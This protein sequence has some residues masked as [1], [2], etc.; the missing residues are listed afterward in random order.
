M[1]YERI[2]AMHEAGD[3]SRCRFGCCPDN[4][5]PPQETEFSE[6]YREASRELA[7][8]LGRSD[9]RVAVALDTRGYLGT[10]PDLPGIV[11]AELEGNALMI[12]DLSGEE[13]GMF[14]MLKVRRARRLLEDCL[15]GVYS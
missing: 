2:K 13:P 4:P 15:I 12:E 7:E 8:R 5:E 11:R 1:A 6:S 14:E 3:H 9:P 10:D